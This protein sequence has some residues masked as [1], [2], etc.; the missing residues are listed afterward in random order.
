MNLSDSN[1][2]SCQILFMIAIGTIMVPINASIVNVSLPSIAGF[3]DA[4]VTTSE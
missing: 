1:R 3:F 2:K 4:T